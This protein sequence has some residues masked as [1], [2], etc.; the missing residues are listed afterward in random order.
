[1]LKKITDREKQNQYQLMDDRL[2]G[3][4]ENGMTLLKA[5]VTNKQQSIRQLSKKVKRDFKNVYNDIM[6]LADL[7]LIDL[8]EHGA[9]KSLKPIPFLN[10]VNWSLNLPHNGISLLLI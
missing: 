7:G 3:E 4:G 1:M 5:I 10:I 2:R 8:K 9:Q 6:F